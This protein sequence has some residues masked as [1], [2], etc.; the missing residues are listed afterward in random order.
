MLICPVLQIVVS[1]L[2]IVLLS[3]ILFQYISNENIGNEKAQTTHHDIKQPSRES[4]F[5]IQRKLKNLFDNHST[6]FFPLIVSLLS[7]N[8][9]LLINGL[10]LLCENI[11]VYW[12]LYIQSPVTDAEALDLFINIT[13]SISIAYFA[14]RIEQ[15]Y[16]NKEQEE[17][18]MMRR[19]AVTEDLIMNLY[20]SIYEGK[21]IIE[22]NMEDH[23][24]SKNLIV[25]FSRSDG[26]A[27]FPWYI[28]INEIVSI[29]LEFHTVNN[30]EKEIPQYN[31]SN[32]NCELD[33]NSI[34]AKLVCDSI[35]DSELENYSA[36][37]SNLYM[38]M[39]ETYSFYIII[40]MSL[41]YNNHIYQKL[42]EYDCI[43][44]KLLI[45]PNSTFI[46]SKNQENIS[47][48]C[49]VRLLQTKRPSPL[50]EGFT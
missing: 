15:V 47:I 38:C 45:I 22:K 41:A 2:F 36:F 13:L 46:R 42:G 27:F 16:K 25:V 10:W 19:K 7:V 9:L 31:I 33:T 3:P 37:L 29:Q 44:L 35:F 32:Y 24:T 17:K 34:T 6:V 1:L 20:N 43:E 12:G 11:L 14:W 21:I 18:D 39:N 5:R 23:K 48:D 26:R 40:N 30:K 28:E 8:L 4:K 50:G 49:I